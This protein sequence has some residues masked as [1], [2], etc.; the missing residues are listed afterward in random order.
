MGFIPSA[1]VASQFL[2]QIEVGDPILFEERSQVF[3]Y[4]MLEARGG[5]TAHINDSLDL[6]MN[7]EIEKLLGGAGAAPQ[8]ANEVLFT[9]H[10]DTILP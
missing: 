3:F 5:E 1:S 8:G 6:V 10:A 4:E 2:P 9:L 7:K